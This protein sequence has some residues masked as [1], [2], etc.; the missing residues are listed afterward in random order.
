MT[1]V[2]NGN[3]VIVSSLLSSSL[4]TAVR[5]RGTRGRTPTSSVP[6][7][8]T[9]V[10][11]T[12]SVGPYRWSRRSGICA[13]S[14]QSERRSADRLHHVGGGEQHTQ[15]QLRQSQFSTSPPSVVCYHR[16]VFHIFLPSSPLLVARR[17]LNWDWRGALVSGSEPVSQSRTQDHEGPNLS[18]DYGSTSPKRSG[19][20]GVVML[21]TA[22]VGT[23]LH[24]SDG[25]MR[26]RTWS[27]L[28]S[29]TKMTTTLSNPVQELMPAY[30]YK[31]AVPIMV[32]FIMG[33][34]TRY[35]D[36]QRQ[37]NLIYTYL[38]SFQAGSL[39]SERSKTCR[40]SNRTYNRY[41]V[42]PSLDPRIYIGVYEHYLLGL[43]TF[44]DWKIFLFSH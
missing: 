20:L 35:I 32:K 38:V 7:T 5:R 22:A 9:R 37:F 36:C 25:G 21:Q 41:L 43:R 28:S 31:G 33:Q 2:R 29:P 11:F 10:E 39:C 15:T 16:R 13:I 23:S 6:H 40:K 18:V 1:R 24:S 19:T 42:S 14:L 17:R 34:E 27:E 26:P 30:V 44:R 3:L 8:R 12:N 4:V